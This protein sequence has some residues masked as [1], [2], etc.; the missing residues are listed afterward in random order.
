MLNKNDF[1]MEQLEERL[2]MF[3][4]YVPYVGTCTRKS[5]SSP[6]PIRASSTTASASN[7]NQIEQ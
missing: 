1:S 5:G 7:L 6:S 3:C 4:I 2:E